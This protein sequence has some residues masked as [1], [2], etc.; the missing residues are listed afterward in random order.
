M[1]IKRLNLVNF[2]NYSKVN[3]ELGPSMN[4]FI[5]E[6]A[7]GKTNILESIVVLALTK[8]YKNINENN[9]IR[10]A[11]KK[12]KIKG[13]VKNDKSLKNLEIEIM[14]TEKVVKVNNKRFYCLADYISNLNIVLFTPDDLELIKGSPSIRRNL[15]NMELSQ[16]SSLYLNTYNQYNK[17]LRT[18]NEYLKILFTNNIAD[19]KYLDI[20]TEQL[21]DKAIVI[22][23]LRNEYLEKI[24]RNINNIFKNITGEE[25]LSI[26][27]KPNISFDNYEDDSL[28]KTMMEIL[29][30]NYQREL[31]I[32]MTMFGP[33]RDDFQ[34][35]L[36]DVDMKL[37]SSQGQQKSAVLAY[38]LSTIPIFEEKNGTKPV[39]LLDDIFSELDLKK[40]N[41]LLKYVNQD[42][43]SIITT[44][45]LKNISK[46]SLE[47]T[48][49]FKVSNGNVERSNN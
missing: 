16:L 24:N 30:K 12:T 40:K 37:F 28:K 47:N 21:I 18:R 33:H 1:V 15:L 23:K 44:T 38:K 49:I 46:K 10:L 39:L 45:D 35:Q 22:Y 5:G 6:N 2:R 31:H 20:L 29:N 7:S 9:L 4:I 25:N 17:I 26:L 43:Q 32:G 48:T 11:K 27:Y 36:N 19:K 34:F 3:L 42:I 13:T 41:R 14:E 8:S